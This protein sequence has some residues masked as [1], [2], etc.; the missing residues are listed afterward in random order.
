MDIKQS[1][2]NF[3][4]AGFFIPPKMKRRFRNLLASAGRY[5]NEYALPIAKQAII[6]LRT[7]TFML[8]GNIRDMKKSLPI[9]N[10]HR[11]CDFLGR[12]VQLRHRHVITRA[13][14]L[15]L[16]YSLFV[17]G[18]LIS[19][20]FTA[21][22]SAVSS[23]VNTPAN[24]N[25]AGQVSLLAPSLKMNVNPAPALQEDTAAVPLDADSTASEKKENFVQTGLAQK[26]AMKEA[27][28][29]TFTIGKGDTLAG[30]LQKAGMTASDSY[31][32]VQAIEPQYDPRKLKPGQKIYLKLPAIETPSRPVEEIR[33]VIDP[34]QT[35][36]VKP[37]DEGR[38]RSSLAQKN[39]ETRLIAKTSNIET[40][41]YGSAIRDGIPVSVIADAIHIFSWDVDFQRDIR[42]GD[43]IDV[44][45]EQL[46]TP[47]GMKIK[48]GNIIYAR[49]DVNGQ[50]IAVYRYELE[51]GAVD[52]FNGE[53]VS[54]RKALMKTPI[55]GARL[56]SGY[57]MRK[58]PVL[59]Y[60]KMHKGVDFAAARGTPIYA[61]GDGTV[62]K[63]SAWGGYGNYIRIRHNADLKTAY[64]HLKGFAKG[65]SAGKRVKQGQVIGYVGTTG[66]STGPHL[67]Y[68]ILQ[69]GRQVNPR[70]IDMPRGETLKGQELQRFLASADKIRRQYASLAGKVKYARR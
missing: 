25:T 24:G 11:I 33:V 65:I 28:E 63:A 14:H 34:L 56:S 49:L 69:G 53:G 50:N 43:V 59:G 9:I 18:A 1:A 62:E 70:T 5:V 10:W 42:H 64:A 7:M 8:F 17:A 45:Y 12:Y 58:H 2:R 38:F 31:K 4:N 41:L 29:K 66:R 32:I 16:R 13:G 46:E 21:G 47:E 44:M 40:S 67:H 68:E 19:L 55:D 61:A 48:T 26:A 23:A 60:T 6:R 57:G 36:M 54:V 30:V 15:R 27:E 51:N 22:F 3:C 35:V 20:V 52:Y 39:V 37:D